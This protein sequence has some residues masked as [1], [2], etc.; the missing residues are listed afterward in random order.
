MNQ[1][2][3]NTKIGEIPMDW[4]VV[5]I[6]EVFTFISTNSFSRADLTTIETEQKIK[7]IHYG[8]IHSKYD[9]Q[10]LD[11]LNTNIPFIKDDAKLPN[12]LNYVLN[13]DLV[14]ADASEDYD[15]I[16]KCV[17]IS[18]IKDEKILSGLHTFL[19]R[20]NNK[21]EFG[22]RTYPFFNS[23]VS[24]QLKKYATGISVLSIS[25]TNLRQ[26]QIPL[27]PLPE[28][29][30]IAEIL[31][32]WDNAINKTTALIKAKE[33]LKKGLMQRIFKEE[34]EI[35]KEKWKEVTLGKVL[36]FTPRPTDKPSSNYLALGIRSHCKGIFQKPDFD[37]KSNAMDTLYAVKKDDL[38]VNITFAWE[39][40]IAIANEEDEGGLV[41]HRFPT[42]TFNKNVGIPEFFRHFIIQKRLRYLLG[43]I[44]P[45]GAGRNRVMS[46][47]DFVK[48]KFRLPPVSTQ[49][50]IAN[51][52]ETADKELELLRK[53]LAKIEE[54]KRGL[55]Q[56]LLTGK[57]R[58][59]V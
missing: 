25:K 34:L 49:T 42:Y 43:L 2:F 57:V 41:S 40:A 21:I 6:D 18:Q 4:E 44:S 56:V 23:A 35:G 47:K 30:K 26:L 20:A 17:E 37:P 13:G 11:V 31:T 16:G 33:E 52:L 8:D 3:K 54:Q 9:S 29:K 36:K 1:Q 53:E 58:V 46:K 51:I 28:Q 19:L 10:I 27:P 39:G 32:T 48:L 15:G 50:K 24:K 5:R 45:G 14:M 7:N 59:K 22:F 55:M 38:V 12:K